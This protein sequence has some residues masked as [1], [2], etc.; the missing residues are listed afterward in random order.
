MPGRFPPEEL[1]IP[2]TIVDDRKP[3]YD[4]P[5]ILAR[6]GVRKAAPSAPGADDHRRLF[7]VEAGF[8]DFLG[9]GAM[10]NAF[11]NAGK[12]NTVVGYREH[13]IPPLVFKFASEMTCLMI[14][15]PKSALI[16]M[17]SS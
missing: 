3:R 6:P 9:F 5:K 16:S 17:S 12:L 10:L 1:H 2:G 8:E 7:Y 4:G 11:N 14:S 15:V 13:P